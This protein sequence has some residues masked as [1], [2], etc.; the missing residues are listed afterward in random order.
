MDV[1]RRL[2]VA[3]GAVAVLL[4][5]YAPVTLALVA[6]A[7]PGVRP[8]PTAEV[9]GLALLVLL[10][11]VW[12]VL[13]SGFATRM[14]CARPDRSTHECVHRARMTE[15]AAQPDEAIRDEADS[16]SCECVRERSGSP[17]DPRR[18]H[19]GRR[20]REGGCHHADRDRDCAEEA[21]RAAKPAD[22]AGVRF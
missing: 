3:A 7:D 5:C 9:A 19:A 4:A 2:S 18:L 13:R 8:L 11:G 6:R 14:A 10:G 22:R 15:E 12:Y 21:Q 17:D 1:K 16:E 20:H